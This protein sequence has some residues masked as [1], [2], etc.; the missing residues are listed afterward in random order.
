MHRGKFNAHF[1]DVAEVTDEILG[2]YM[3]G[4]KNMS[5]EEKGDLS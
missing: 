3:L 4:I 1:T 2:E 5:E